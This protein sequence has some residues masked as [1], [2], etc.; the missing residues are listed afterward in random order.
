MQLVESGSL[1]GIESR[2]PA[3]GL[4]TG[5]AGKS[6]DK[7]LEKGKPT[8]KFASPP[9]VSLGRETAKAW[10]VQGWRVDMGMNLLGV[11]ELSVSCSGLAGL[12]E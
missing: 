3:L 6:Q 1:M 5:L 7:I 12:P 8:F 2:P 4:A 10:A 9:S 11:R